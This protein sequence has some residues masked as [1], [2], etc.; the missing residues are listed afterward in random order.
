MVI[1]NNIDSLLYLGVT[2]VE[3]RKYWMQLDREGYQ[4]SP[5]P[6][7]VEC[8]PDIAAVLFQINSI[9][10]GYWKLRQAAW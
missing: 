3:E 1:C 7:K 6:K 2:M 5:Y 8:I 9:R 4:S 10:F